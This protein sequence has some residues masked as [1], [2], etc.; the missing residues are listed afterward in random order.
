MLDKGLLDLWESCPDEPPDEGFSCFWAARTER[1]AAMYANSVGDVTILALMV[2]CYM[3]FG[4][5]GNILVIYVYLR[6][7]GV[8]PFSNF[9]VCQAVLHCLV[10]AIVAPYSVAYEY[11]AVTL[12]GT[13]MSFEFLRHSLVLIASMFMCATALH[14]YHSLQRTVVSFVY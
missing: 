9:V 10:L 11:H 5:L 13:C 4:L 14:C 7:S 12:S 2:T 3:F 6:A 1:A 8:L